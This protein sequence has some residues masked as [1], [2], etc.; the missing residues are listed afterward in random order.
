MKRLIALVTVV[1]LLFVGLV[2]WLE[3]IDA[4]DM[5]KHNCHQ[6]NNTR[7]SSYWQFTYDGKGNIN[8]GFPVFYTETEYVCD[9]YNRW[10]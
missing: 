1:V 6:T 10:R 3:N 7:L 5:A 8:G 2:V 9:D 4:K